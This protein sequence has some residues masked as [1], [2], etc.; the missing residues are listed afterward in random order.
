MREPIGSF[1]RSDAR[2]CFKTSMPHRTSS[3]PRDGRDTPT[4]ADRPYGLR[5][6]ADLSHVTIPYER[7]NAPCRSDMRLAG[8]LMRWVGSLIVRR[9]TRRRGLRAAR[10][11]AIEAPRR[12][13]CEVI[14]HSRAG[15]AAVYDGYVDL[16]GLRYLS[17]AWRSH[18]RPP[19]ARAARAS[20]RERKGWRASRRR[21]NAR[22]GRADARA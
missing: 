12:E 11:I 10:R 22:A 6:R 17:C 18:V 1:T 13:P 20:C 21:R 5:F 19:A 2:C 14:G 16:C 7:C 9:R 15:E 8:T 4:P 3:L